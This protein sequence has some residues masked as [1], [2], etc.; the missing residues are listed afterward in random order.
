MWPWLLVGVGAASA[1]VGAYLGYSAQSDYDGFR[2]KPMT[3]SNY[4][5]MR[6]SIDRRWI[7]A[8]VLY[9]VS[10]VATSAGV[11]WLLWPDDDE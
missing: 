6:N 4:I 9:A 8:D 11:A 10:L 7:G 2:T 1:G 3:D 5:D